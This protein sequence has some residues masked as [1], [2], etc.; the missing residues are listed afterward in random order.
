MRPN[1]KKTERRGNR[2]WMTKDGF[3]FNYAAE[4]HACGASATFY[5]AACYAYG[6]SESLPKELQM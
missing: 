6:G 5:T 2:F 4:R 3:P 1:K